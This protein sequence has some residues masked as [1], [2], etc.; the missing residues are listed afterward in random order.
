MAKLDLLETFLQGNIMGITFTKYATS[1]ELCLPY[2]TLGRLVTLHRQ[3]HCSHLRNL[4]HPVVSII[5]IESG[6]TSYVD[7]EPV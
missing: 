5:R 3:E 6:V 2:A 4:V 1:S 7:T